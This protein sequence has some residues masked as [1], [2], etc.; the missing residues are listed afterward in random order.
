MEAELSDE[1]GAF[2]ISPRAL[3]AMNQY[4][5]NE[6][7]SAAGETKGIIASLHTDPSQGL[8]SEAVET[9]RSHFGANRYREAPPTSF[10]TLLFE[11]LKDPTLILLMFAATVSTVLGL[12]IDRQENHW[13]EGVAI[14]VAVILVSMVGSITDYQKELQF[15][16]INAVSG[17]IQIKV[18]RDGTE[19]LVGNE[20]LVVGDI[21]VL[22]T[23]DNIVAD[24]LYISGYGLSTDESALTGEADIIKKNPEKDPWC[25][26]GTQVR[27]SSCMQRHTRQSPIGN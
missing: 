20:E 4:K 24:G 21:M 13:I 3:A 8:K 19:Q 9:S 23:G 12:A 15:R 26:S 10:L 17:R 22:D 16:A 5:N 27:L 7:L 11:A 18:I 1:Q 2:G 25:R 6:E 14:W